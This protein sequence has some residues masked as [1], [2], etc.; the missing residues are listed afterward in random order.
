[1][2]VLIQ[3]NVDYGCTYL[4]SALSYKLKAKL[5]TSQNK[6]IRFVFGK[7]NRSHVRTA[8]LKDINWLPVEHRVAQ[9]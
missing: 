2:S 4:F 5:Q 1:M 6:L 7:H 9:K 3:S 8:E